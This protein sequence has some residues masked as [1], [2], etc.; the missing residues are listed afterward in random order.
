MYLRRIIIVYLFF[1]VISFYTWS[2]TLVSTEPTLKTVVLENF[3][4]I[5][6]PNC[7]SG[8]AIAE[9]IRAANPDRVIIVGVHQG[10]YAVP[11][12]GQPDFRTAFGDA[13]ASQAA[14]TGYPA[15]TINRHFFPAYAMNNGTAMSRSYWA[16]AS[17]QILA[18]SSPVNVGVKSTFDAVTRQLTVDVELY[19]T[20]TPATSTNYINVALLESNVIA[21]QAGA[22]SNYNH[23]NILRHFL[24]GQWGD[25]VKNIQAGAFRT[26]TYTYTVPTTYN[27]VNC[28]IAVYVAQSHQEI[29]S[30]KRVAANGGSTFLIG[31]FNQN[32]YV[33]TGT[34]FNIL[35][36]PITFTSNITGN[37]SFNISLTSSDAPN[38][39]NSSFTVNGN[40]YTNTGTGNF[41]FN[42]PD[43][44]TIN[45][46]PGNTPKIATY[47]LTITSNSQ[48]YLSPLIKKI[49]ILSNVTDIIVNN[50]ASWGDGSSVTPANFQS[51][52]IQGLI[53]AGETKY[54]VIPLSVFEIIGNAG[55]LDNI[56]GV[57]YNVGWSFPSLTDA[58]VAVFENYLDNGGNLLISGQD[59]GWD[60]FDLTNGGNGTAIT[61]SFYN[62]YLKSSFVNDGSTANNQ[63]TINTNDAVFGS[64]G[65]SVIID[66]YGSGSNTF[67]YPDEINPL[68]GG[69]SFFYYNGNTSK[70]GG[71]RS[72]GGGYKTVNMGVSLEMISDTNVRKD[73]ITRAHDW[74]HNIVNINEF[75]EP[76]IKDYICYPNPAQ[77]F[78]NI[79]TNNKEDLIIQLFDISGKIIK[80]ETIP[81]NTVN[82]ELNLKNVGTGLYYYSIFN[83]NIIIA[84]HILNVVK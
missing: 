19:Y 30:G 48:P 57:Y 28:D 80:K 73:I 37:E 79:I 39:W 33:E 53:N 45:I 77:D 65:N 22:S 69:T 67:M 58:C 17:N 3:T 64:V 32:Y 84:N 31:K 26:K 70:I 63:L 23:K 52:F 60:N 15:G 78:V 18:Q 34:P 38:D 49:Y 75:N 83:N 82:Y 54:D 50:E 20:A 10:S 51:N 71:V 6:C 44:I 13:L 7:P 12:A 2:Q 4:G 29:L 16:A 68:S 8:H 74:F 1:N 35:N 11:S 76:C 66:A 14:L 59:I 5:N 46:I 56:I 24:T 27:I 40:T 81:A 9:S 21:Y 55:K 36:I 43:D 47:T 72:T 41:T 61:Q 25:T 62:N 42:T